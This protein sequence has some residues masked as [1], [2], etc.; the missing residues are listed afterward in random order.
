MKT[1]KK[2]MG[3][4]AHGEPLF[5]RDEFLWFFEKRI[6]DMIRNEVEQHFKYMMYKC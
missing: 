4:A 1:N 2:K 3:F 6:A 5:D